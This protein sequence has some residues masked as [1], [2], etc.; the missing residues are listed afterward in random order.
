MNMLKV[1]L[2]R[3][4]DFWVSAG[5]AADLSYNL[6]ASV[7]DEFGMSLQVRQHDS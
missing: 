2:V 5:I 1:L 6:K 4:V 3:K 7:F